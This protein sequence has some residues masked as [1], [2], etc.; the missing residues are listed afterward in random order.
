MDFSG[1]T[2]RESAKQAAQQRAASGMQTRN[3]LFMLAPS[4]WVPNNRKLPVV[5]Y[6]GVLR[7]AD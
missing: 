7:A 2:M 1:Y 5:L 4:D 6:R 3:E